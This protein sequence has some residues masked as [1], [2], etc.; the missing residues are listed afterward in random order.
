MSNTLLILKQ[1]MCFILGFDEHTQTI[2]FAIPNSKNISVFAGSR[3]R[4][5]HYESERLEHHIDTF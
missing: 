3:T 2:W 1:E 4:I 5:A